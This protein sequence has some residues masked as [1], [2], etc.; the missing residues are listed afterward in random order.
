MDHKEFAGLMKAMAINAG[1][2][3]EKGTLMLYYET[4]KNIATIDEFREACKRVLMTWKYSR[5][6]P[7]AVI[8]E[9]IG[10]KPQQIEH[11]AVVEANRI[12]AHLKEWGSRKWPVLDDPVTKYLMTRR[13]YYPSWSQ[14]LLE[15]EEKWWVKEFVEAYQAHSAADDALQLE[16]VPDRIK[17][18]IEN[19]GGKNE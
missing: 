17:P 8:L 7:I 6:P 2:E 19:I 4:F 14:N 16:D 12:L 13:W 10:D 9:N 5:L 3:L 1:V 18:L 11:K 15:S